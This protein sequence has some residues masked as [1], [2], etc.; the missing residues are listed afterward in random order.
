MM[1][2]TVAYNDTGRI[3]GEPVSDYGGTTLDNIS[4]KIIVTGI[5]NDYDARLDFDVVVPVAGRTK[6]GNPYLAL[7]EGEDDTR[8]CIITRAIMRGC[9]GDLRLPIQLV[10]TKGDEQYASKNK[11]VLRISSAIN[12]ADVVQEVYEPDIFHAF[13]D[14]DEEGGVITFTR[15]DGTTVEINV[16][17][18]FVAWS[19]VDTEWPEEPSD[20]KVPSTK[21]AGDTF[22]KKNLIAPERLL[23][24]DSDGNV[25]ANGPR[26]VE[27][28]S[29]TPSDDNL[30]T[31]KLVKEDLDAKA[32]DSDVVHNDVGTPVWSDSIQYS[33]QSTVI[34]NFDLYI[35]QNDNNIGHPPDE[36]DTVWW[37]LVQGGGGGGGGDD[38]GA[39]KVF[40]LGDGS[41]LQFI[42]AHNFNSY[43]VA[44]LLYATSGSMTDSETMV[45]R[46]SKNRVKVT[47]HSAPA[48]NE[49]TIVLYRPGI[50]PE[51]C[52]TSIN[53]LT[54][55]VVFTPSDFGAVSTEA[56]QGLTSEQ[57]GNARDNIGLGTAAVV[58][59]GTGP[60]NVPPLNADSKLPN[61]VIPSYAIGNY[62][63]N[64][65]TKADLVTLSTGEPS[66][67]ATVS[68]D[69]NV[70]NNG[71]WIL[72]GTY[73][74]LTD[75][76]QIL[77]P[78]SVLSV[79]GQTGV[80][81]LSAS[82]VGAVAVNAAI[83]A[84]IYTKVTVD[85][86]GLITL[87][88][89]LAAAD[90]P[91]LPA[92][93]IGSGTL[94]IARIP[95]G[96]GA[97]KVLKLDSAGLGGQSV[98]LNDDGTAFIWYT[99]SSST[100]AMFTGTIMGN[101]TSKVFTFNHSLSSVPM[102]VMMDS[103]GKIVTS[104]L[105]VT[106]TTIT[107]TFYTAPESGETYTIKAIA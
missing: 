44:H 96:N 88:E 78:G 38:P 1:E 91:T 30:P 5:P 84:G 98:R 9:K 75:W 29:P 13:V 101:G 86:K 23:I 82:D 66:D 58:D 61:S 72:D 11:L 12:A 24:T 50:G 56:S 42:C 21:L 60:G 80:V 104:A 93:K 19:D 18:D 46:I 47:F 17:D 7:I 31:E 87:G 76:I 22:L 32:D 77:A 55:D 45:E 39:Y 28:W 6:K 34:H 106:A 52:V 62:L 14:V 25:L 74:V 64:V 99:P 54:G 43:H 85:E 2:I 81:I 36:A 79:N 27:A 57:Q 35:S 59:V 51:S 107:A 8:Y 102:V 95:T 89:L 33:A 105:E 69:P 37:Q 16:D 70:A 48:T 63:G 71:M 4:T 94:N 41:T 92:A 26:I 10:L 97:N 40:T 68:N 100:L 53:G 73:S 20:A 67:Y 3:L 65:S 103:T 90:I 83:T 49:Y 15:L